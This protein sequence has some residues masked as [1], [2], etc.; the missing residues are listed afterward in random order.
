MRKSVLLTMVLAFLG[1]QA[2][3]ALDRLFA[4][5]PPKLEL[6]FGEGCERAALSPDGRFVAGLIRQSDG[7]YLGVAD[8][9]GDGDVEPFPVPDPPARAQTFAWH[10]SS[11]W[12]AYGCADQVRLIDCSER[13]SHTLFANPN[14]RQVLFRGDRILARA[15]ESVTMWN[16]KTGKLTFHLKVR[17]LLHADLTADG[18]VLALGCFGE[19]VRLLSVPSKRVLRTLAD[20]LV[21]AAISFCNDDRWVAVAL[22]TGKA[23]EDHARLYDVASGRQLGPNMG[24]PRLRGMAVSRD[25]QRLLTCGEASSTVWQPSTGQKICTRNGTSSLVEALS[26]DGRLA[27]ASDSRAKVVT[28]WDAQSGQELHRLDHP[29]PPRQINWSSSNRLEVTGERYRLWWIR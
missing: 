5:V 24:Q 14:V 20:G 19:G 26:P 13:K 27:A 15:D 11:R 12:V 2:G 25:G 16:V 4:S 9:L 17:H 18:K 22:R 10:E 23:P 6:D 28:V 8:M 7:W 29:A 21:P 3:S 1:F